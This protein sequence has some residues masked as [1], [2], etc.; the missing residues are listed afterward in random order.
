MKQFTGKD[1][2]FEEPL[3]PDIVIDTESDS[4]EE[5][6]RKLYEIVYPIIRPEAG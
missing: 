4:V 3:E 6:C 1:S 2:A 5:S